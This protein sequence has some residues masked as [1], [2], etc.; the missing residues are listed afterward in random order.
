MRKLYELPCSGLKE[1]SFKPTWRKIQSLLL[2]SN[3]KLIDDELMKVVYSMKANYCC[4]QLVAHNRTHDFSY[5]YET[6]KTRFQ[7]CI[8][9]IYHHSSTKL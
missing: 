2:S 3:N 5:N 4:T 1:I 9:C 7:L 8:V 6:V